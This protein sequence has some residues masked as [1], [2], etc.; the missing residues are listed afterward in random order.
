[1][2]IHRFERYWT[3]V[4]LLLIVG[5]IATVTYGAVG[6]GVQMVDDSGGTVDPQSLGDTQFADPGVRKVGENHYAVYVVARQ[7]LFQ[8]GTNRPIVV[9]AGSTVTFHVTSADVTHGFEVAGTNVNAMV[10][11]GQ[12][13]ELTVRFEEPATYGVLCNEYCGAGH[14]AMEGLLKVVPPS[15]YNGTDTGGA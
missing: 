14:H 11:P 5:F 10:I 1:M 2:E 4:A 3:V 9:P 15:E 6:V 8:P 13:T 7:F 12:V